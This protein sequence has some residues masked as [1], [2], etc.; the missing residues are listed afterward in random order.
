MTTPSNAPETPSAPTPPTSESDAGKSS[1]RTRLL[2]SASIA[3]GAVMSVLELMNIL[4]P[5]PELPTSNFFWLLVGLLTL[6]LGI[7]ELVLNGR[8][9][10]SGGRK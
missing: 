3:V 2:A 9:L 6:A 7:L 4:H 1:G 10:G 8:D 5:R